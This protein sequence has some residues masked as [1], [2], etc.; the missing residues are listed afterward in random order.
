MH[1]ANLFA[2]FALYFANLLAGLFGCFTDLLYLGCFALLYLRS[3]YGLLG[4]F[5]KTALGLLDCEA[6]FART[7]YAWFA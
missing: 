3:Y 7:D 6:C 2:R 4:W 1:E 5:A